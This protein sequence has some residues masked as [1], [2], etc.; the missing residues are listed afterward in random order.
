MISINY[1]IDIMVIVILTSSKSKFNICLHYDQCMH[2]NVRPSDRSKGIKSQEPVSAC[3]V[4]LSINVTEHLFIYFPMTKLLMIKCEGCGRCTALT[5]YL[6]QQRNIRGFN[7]LSL[8]FKPP[9]SELVLSTEIHT[10]LS[11][12]Y[13]DLATPTLLS[14]AFV[15]PLLS[16]SS[17]RSISDDSRTRR[18]DVTYTP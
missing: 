2:T 6:Y 1:V 10:I 16:L 7:K 12:K 18:T 13:M 15:K 5:S 8:S 17:Y 11:A 3:I 14:S 9:T 4:H